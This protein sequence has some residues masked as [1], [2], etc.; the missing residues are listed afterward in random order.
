[1]NT[2]VTVSSNSLTL[3]DKPN[4]VTKPTGVMTSPFL[5][6]NPL[7]VILNDSTVCKVEPTP[8][9][10]LA[11]TFTDTFSPNPVSVVAPIPKRDT[12]TTSRSSYDGSGTIIWGLV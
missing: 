4:A 9:V 2:S 1:M 10:E 12:P 8:T 3:L 7:L 6:P 11:P 5:N